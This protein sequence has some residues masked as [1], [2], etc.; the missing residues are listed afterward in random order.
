MRLKSHI[1]ISLRRGRKREDIFYQISIHNSFTLLPFSVI[2]V[3]RNVGG[4]CVM[5]R[6]EFQ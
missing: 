2:S 4:Y 5:C 1:A 6:K 3:K